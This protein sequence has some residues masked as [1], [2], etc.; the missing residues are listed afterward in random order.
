MSDILD[1]ILGQIPETKQE[2][3]EVIV[4]GNLQAPEPTPV[5]KKAITYH[6][7][8]EKEFGPRR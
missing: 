2:A 5:S 4:P 1:T 7:D 8:F 3:P 6:P